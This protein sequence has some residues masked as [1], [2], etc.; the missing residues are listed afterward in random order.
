MIDKA[1]EAR[2]LRYFHVEHWRVGTI[3]RQLHVHPSTVDRVLSQAGV[4]AERQP[5][6]SLLDPYRVFIRETLQQ[7]PKLTASRLYEMVRVRGYVRPA[8]SS[9]N[10]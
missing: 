7:Y 2:I 6:R 5:R 10:W 8:W 4:S 9:T 1:L 3:A